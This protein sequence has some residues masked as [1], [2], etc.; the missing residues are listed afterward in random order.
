MK[1]DA[2]AG[3]MPVYKKA[4]ERRGECDALRTVCRE[5]ADLSV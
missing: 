4:F 3:G 5:G 1:N 2:M